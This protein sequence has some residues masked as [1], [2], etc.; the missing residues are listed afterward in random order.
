MTMQT[1]KQ[2]FKFYI[3]V[4]DDLAVCCLLQARA[5]C[6]EVWSAGIAAAEGL[7]GL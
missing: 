3:T 7:C 1:W 5:A 6:L 4:V 2:R